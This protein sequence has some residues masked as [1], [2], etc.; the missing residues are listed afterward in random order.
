M[1][2]AG[3]TWHEGKREERVFAKKDIS[4]G[5]EIVVGYPTEKFW[6]KL[7]AGRQADLL[8]VFNFNCSCTACSLFYDAFIVSLAHGDLARAHAFADL[9]ME[10]AI[11]CKGGDNPSRNED[12]IEADAAEN[13]PMASM[14]TQW[15]SAAEEAQTDTQ[16]WSFGLEGC[17]RWIVRRTLGTT[18]TKN[19]G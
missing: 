12:Q 15:S 4:K 10:R 7:K 18:G 1:S 5:E 9:A 2:N 8:K 14:S 17:A 16:D 13:H 3:Y 11:I 19:G 6:G